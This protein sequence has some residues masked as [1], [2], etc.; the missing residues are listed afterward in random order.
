[1]SR[2]N[3]T[4]TARNLRRSKTMCAV[5]RYGTR[6]TRGGRGITVEESSLANLMHGRRHCLSWRPTATFQRGRS[7]YGS[8]QAADRGSRPILDVPVLKC[9]HGLVGDA[10]VAVVGA[11]G[12]REVE[13]TR[14]HASEEKPVLLGRRQPC[15]WGG[16]AWLGAAVRA[17]IG[18]LPAPRCRHGRTDRR[19]DAYSE[20]ADQLHRHEGEAGGQA[21]LI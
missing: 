8:T 4:S 3:V 10:S 17:A 18:Q 19:R 15:P 2:G 13:G 12:S 20:Q 16:S 21:L 9:R 1:M 5:A 6:P 14:R 7:R 11:M